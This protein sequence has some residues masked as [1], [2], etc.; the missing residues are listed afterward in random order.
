MGTTLAEYFPF[1]AG[2]GANVTEAQWREMAESWLPTGI[3]SG[4]TNQF[5]VA[6]RAA[7]ANMSVDVATGQARIQGHVGVST[8]I[9]NVGVAANGT[10]NP[11]ID[12]II[13]RAN[14]TTNIVEVDILQGTPA[15]SPVAPTLTQNSAMWEISLAQIAVAAGAVS[16]ATAN[17]TDERTIKTP[18]GAAASGDSDQ[19]VL[20]VQVFS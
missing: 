19:I 4:I 12:R 9:I 3:V 10:G 16:I 1:D 6:Q 14:F 18:A 13:L 20:G 7:G 5:A 11:R 2:A 8:S 15:G 17:I